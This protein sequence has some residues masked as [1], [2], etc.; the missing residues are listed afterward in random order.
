MRTAALSFTRTRLA[1]PSTISRCLSSTAVR[2][3][4]TA[5]SRA[6]KAADL[7]TYPESAI[8]QQKLPDGL[9]NRHWSEENATESEKDIRADKETQLE[10]VIKKAPTGSPS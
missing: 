3:R 8:T 9:G 5:I 7:K 6:E 1:R 10:G 4:P 2:A